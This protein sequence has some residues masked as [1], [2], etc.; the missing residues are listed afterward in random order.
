M[1][2]VIHHYEEGVSVSDDG[3]LHAYVITQPLDTAPPG[4]IDWWQPCDACYY[5]PGQVW[6]VPPPSL[7]AALDILTTP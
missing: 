3:T 1:T 5:L 4:W 7:L 2:P 6:S